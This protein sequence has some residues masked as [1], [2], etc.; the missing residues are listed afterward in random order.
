LFV[1]SH[2]RGSYAGSLPAIFNLTL[3]NGMGVTG[4]VTRPPEF[5][6]TNALGSALRVRT[7][8]E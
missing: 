4:S 7:G 2:P 3:L 5:A 8:E 1:L 6:P